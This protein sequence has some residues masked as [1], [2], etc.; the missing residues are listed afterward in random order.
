MRGDFNGRRTTGL[1]GA[2]LFLLILLFAIAALI[3][4]NVPLL[5]AGLGPFFCGIGVLV[6]LVPL[7]M[8]GRYSKVFDHEPTE[9]WG[10]DTT[11]AKVRKLFRNLGVAGAGL[12]IAGLFFMIS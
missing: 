5:A 12:A 4:T 1:G 10:R 3:K 8:Y 6:V 2:A 11:G 9:L 7:M